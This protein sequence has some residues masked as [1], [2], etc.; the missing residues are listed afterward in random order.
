MNQHYSQ[1]YIAVD[2]PSGVGVATARA[3]KL[4][5][6]KTNIVLSVLLMTRKDSNNC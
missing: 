6:S 4:K 1:E 5:Q 3:N 2:L